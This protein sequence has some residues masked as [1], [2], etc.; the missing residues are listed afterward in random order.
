MSATEYRA[1]FD[2]ATIPG[3]ATR[4]LLAGLLF[5]GQGQAVAQGEHDDVHAV[6]GG[7]V[8]VEVTD[9]LDQFALIAGVDH[10][11]VGKRVVDQ[12]GAAGPTR[13]TTSFQ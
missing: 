10:A 12:D 5:A 3:K 4:L 8:V 11:A 2:A 9:G 7:G 1:Q 6:V 13:G